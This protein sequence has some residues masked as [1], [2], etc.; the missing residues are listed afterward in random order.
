HNL[1]IAFVIANNKGY[2]IIKQ[3][4]LAF[5]GN[6][7][8]IGMDFVE[9]EIDFVGLARSFG[10]AAER[11]ADP[12]AVRPAVEAAVKSGRPALIDLIVEGTV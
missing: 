2:R 10:V 7:E 6:R 1:P 11:I 3:R 9:P 4:L 12:A 5:H 8:F